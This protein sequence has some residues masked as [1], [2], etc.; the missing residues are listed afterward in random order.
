MTVTRS[1]KSGATPPGRREDQGEAGVGLG[2]LL[3][4]IGGFLDLL[5]TIADK[6][7]GEFSRAGEVDGD[8][9]VKAVYGFSVRVGGGGKPH[10]EPFGNVKQAEQGAVVEEEREPIV[11]VFDEDDRILIVA[12]LPGVG[13]DDIRF[14]V[15]GD[16]LSLSARHGERKYSKEV[17]LSSPVA[18]EGA[19]SSYRNGVFELKLTKRKESSDEHRR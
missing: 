11:D 14:E 6:T 17:L 5:S 18:A 1:R 10:I 12:E 2:G 19:V 4:S 13:A 9:G 3:H 16:V 8:K 15:D 7:G